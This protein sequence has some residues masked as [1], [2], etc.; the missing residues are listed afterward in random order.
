MPPPI[1]TVPLFAIIYLNTVLI[2]FIFLKLDAPCP[3][4][5][6]PWRK[7]SKFH[8]S[9]KFSWPFQNSCHHLWLPLSYCT[10]L[11]SYCMHNLSLLLNNNYY[12]RRSLINSLFNLS[13]CTELCFCKLNEEVLRMLRT[14]GSQ[15]MLDIIRIFS[16]H[17]Y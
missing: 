5:C 12:P 2:K 4:S 7:T 8:L 16:S 11:A 13:Q 3:N 15:K 14:V 9:R 10:Y 17:L 6:S 1:A